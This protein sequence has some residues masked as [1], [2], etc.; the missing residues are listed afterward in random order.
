MEFGLAAQGDSF[1]EVKQKLEGMIQDYLYDALVGEDREHALELLRR[2]APWWVFARYYL[3]CLREALRDSMNVKTFIEP[4]GL[5][6][7]RCS[8]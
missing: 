7:K 3:S 8:S 1:A 5:E 6:P 2:R 4:L